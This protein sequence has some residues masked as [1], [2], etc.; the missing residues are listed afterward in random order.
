MSLSVAPS[1]S[2]PCEGGFAILRTA[3][4]LGSAESNYLRQALSDVALAPA[5]PVKQKDWFKVVRRLRK[6]MRVGPLRGVRVTAGLKE[7]WQF[8]GERAGIH[9]DRLFAHQQ[10][11]ADEVMY[12][13]RTVRE[14]LRIAVHTGL[15]I[16]HTHGAGGDRR[17]G[18]YKKQGAWYQLSFPGGIEGI[19][20]VLDWLETMRD[21][22]RKIRKT[23]V[24]RTVQEQAQRRAEEFIRKNPDMVREISYVLDQ[25]H[26]REGAVAVTSEVFRRV[27]TRVRF[28]RKYVLR[29]VENDP[30]LADL[31]PPVETMRANPAQAR[32]EQLLQQV[33]RPPDF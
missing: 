26:C 12:N 25:P 1:V 10:T 19:N 16:R 21:A 29:A 11:I 24:R 13:V 15:L 14:A 9:G 23:N 7:I 3:A 5:V 30:T 18:A 6:N 20:K 28:E 33:F 17:P 4:R 2:N 31:Y 22:R 27:R 8:A 32:I